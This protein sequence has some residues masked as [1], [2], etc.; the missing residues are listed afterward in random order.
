MPKDQNWRRK[1][2]LANT[3]HGATD[4]TEYRV[5]LGMRKRCRYVKHKHY[6]SYGG[7]G[8]TVC[9][10]WQVFENFLADMGPRPSMRHTLDRINNDGHYEPSNCRW[11][12][13]DEQHN[14]R[15]S[16]R[17]LEHNGE[18]LTMAQWAHRLG[19]PPRTLR[20]RLRRGWSLADSVTKPLTPGY[21]DHIRG[22]ARNRGGVAA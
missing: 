12:T 21:G 18:R 6:A 17:F 1:I 13:S 11:A 3:R 19:I 20:A 5:W 7:R 14:N 4:T 9:D 10:R 15:R 16:N 2:G 8:I 22:Q